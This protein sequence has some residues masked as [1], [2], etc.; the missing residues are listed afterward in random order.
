MAEWRYL[1]EADTEA[2]VVCG[3]SHTVVQSKQ[4]ERRDLGEADTEAL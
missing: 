2:L 4:A 1:N 3:D